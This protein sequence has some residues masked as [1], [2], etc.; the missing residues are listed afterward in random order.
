M[1]MCRV[2]S[3]L[4]SEMISLVEE[5]LSSTMAAGKAATSPGFANS[6]F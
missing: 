2:L 3:A 5:K 1:Q 4:C 6:V